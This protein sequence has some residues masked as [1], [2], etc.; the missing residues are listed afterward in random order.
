MKRCG[1]IRARK[2]VVGRFSY[3]RIVIVENPWTK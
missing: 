3:H 1:K 2:I